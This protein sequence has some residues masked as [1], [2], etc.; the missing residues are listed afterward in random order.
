MT[1]PGGGAGSGAGSETGAGALDPASGAGAADPA[2]GSGLGGRV[3]SAIRWSAINSLLQRVSQ[4]GVGVLLARLI[5][6]EQF[7]VFAVALVV[8]N[9]VLSVSEMGVSVAL[10]RTDEPV[11]DLAPTVTTLSILSGCLLFGICVVGAPYFAEAMDTPEATGVIRLMSFALVIAGASAVPGAL[12][13][14]EFRQDHKFAADTSAFVVGTTVVV[15]MALMGFGAWSLAW[16]RIATNLTAAVV[17]FAFTKQRYRPGFD[18]VKAREALSFGLPLAGASLLVFGVLNVDY[19]MVGHLLGTTALGFYM[20]AFNLANWPV[21]AF[22]QPVRSVSLAAFSQ[23][24]SDQERFAATFARALRLLALVTVPACVLLGSLSDPIVRVVYG[25]RWAPSAAPLALLVLLGA[26]RV[27]LE[28]GYDY[29]ASAGRSK[30]I[31]YIHVLWLVVL[32]PLLALGAHLDGIRGV[33]AAQSVVVLLFIVPAY[34][35]AFKPYGLRPGLLGA[36]VA[37]PVLGGVVMGAVAVGV[38]W[39][40]DEPLLRLL[41]GGALS[42]LAYAAVVYPLRGEVIGVLRRGGA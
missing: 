6:P 35:V 5:A 29:L 34:L 12:L 42:T 2:T 11:E 33:A 32:V 23:V 3:G 28:L 22:S 20:M 27:A 14:R 41:V 4:V 21:G 1:G 24:R 25:E 30:A 39:A 37:R 38:Q 9:I 7:G 40:V 31:L 26:L 19:I 18:P 17:M 15:V 10:V 8:L 16:S 36:A 13:Q